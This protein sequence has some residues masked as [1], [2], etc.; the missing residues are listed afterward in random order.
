MI[1]NANQEPVGIARTNFKK[2]IDIAIVNE[3]DKNE[4]LAS[5]DL[6]R[7]IEKAQ[8]RVIASRTYYDHLQ[9]L[10]ARRIIKKQDNGIRGKQAVFY[11]LTNEAKNQKK[12]RN[13]RN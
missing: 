3:L 9:R 11:L 4:P 12:I 8:G 6:K 7:N 5:S 1:V 10:T 2:Y 13:Y